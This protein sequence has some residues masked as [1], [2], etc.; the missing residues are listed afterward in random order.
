MCSNG[1]CLPVESIFCLV[2]PLGR[3]KRLGEGERVRIERKRERKEGR[4][5]G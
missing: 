5:K 3:V 4:E 2:F 1:V